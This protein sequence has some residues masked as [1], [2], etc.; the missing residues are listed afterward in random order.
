[1]N[2]EFRKARLDDLDHIEEIFNV[3]KKNM[4]L[5]NNPNQWDDT[6]PNKDIATQD[7]DNAV[8][9]VATLDGIP[10]AYFALIS[11]VD[12]TYINID[13]AWLND[14]PYSVIHRIAVSKPKLGIGAKCIDF[15]FTT[16]NNLKIDTHKD[17]LPMQKL[18]VNKGFTY[19]GIIYLDNK[20]ERLAYQAK[21]S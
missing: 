5:A 6:Y 10:V 9:W 3:A 19:C 21:R 12:P 20:E 11:G 1:M 7:I 8:G 4:I 17:N 18:L 16:T 13:G 14:E 15:A 2:I